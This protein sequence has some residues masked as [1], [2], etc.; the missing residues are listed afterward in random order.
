METL[1]SFVV[2]FVLSVFMALMA[3]SEAYFFYVG[4]RDGWVLNPSES[5]SHWAE[6]NRFQVNDSLVFKYKKGEDSVLVVREEDFDKCNVSNP[7]E[8][9]DTGSSV[10]TFDRSGP[11]FFI[12]GV[13]EKCLKGEKL[14]VVVLAVRSKS[15]VTPAPTSPSPASPVSPGSSPSP[16]SPVSPG[17]SPSPA[18][19]VSP[20]PSHSPVSP[21]SPVSPTPAP[22]PSKSS[23]VS[24]TPSPAPSKSSPVSPTPAPA[25][26]KRSPVSPTPSPAPSKSSPVSPTPSPP[27]SNSSSPASSPSPSSPPPTS[28][29]SA[30]SPSA[31]ASPGPSPDSSSSV[32]IVPEIGFGVLFAVLG[33]GLLL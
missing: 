21:V 2:L 1:R 19:P 27:P 26:S 22:A 4:G 18:S 31:G 17:S 12:S 7:V 3:S 14:V 5:Y 16:A 25:P 10:F 8:R 6:R 24:P 20:A 29:I 9:R 32:L 15:P 28:T 30:P 33:G 23:P 13:E 11:F